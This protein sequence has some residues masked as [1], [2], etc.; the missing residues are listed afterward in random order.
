MAQPDQVRR[1]QQ[2][3]VH[4]VQRAAA[5]DPMA[6]GAQGL[7][8]AIEGVGLALG[9][10]RPVARG[11]GRI[12][13]IQAELPVGPAAGQG[14]GLDG[15]GSGPP[16]DQREGRNGGD[17]RNGDGDVHRLDTEQPQQLQLVSRLN[18]VGDAAIRR[19][20]GQSAIP[21]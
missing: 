3:L 14:A 8:G 19:G 17:C 2:A 5:I 20:D 1:G 12:A 11:A 13:Q 18:P 7:D 16:L 10:H 6:G 15:H 9:L 4:P 21:G